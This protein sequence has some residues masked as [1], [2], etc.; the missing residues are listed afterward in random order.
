M[1]AKISVWRVKKKSKYMTLKVYVTRGFCSASCVERKTSHPH[2]T[3]ATWSCSQRSR[4]LLVSTKNRNLQH[5]KS[6]IRGLSVKSDWLR[7]QSSSQDKGYVGSGEYGMKTLRMLR[8]SG[9]ARSQPLKCKWC[10]QEPIGAPG[11]RSGL[12]RSLSFTWEHLFK[13][14][15]LLSEYWTDA[16]FSKR[17]TIRH[18]NRHRIIPE[19]VLLFFPSLLF[20]GF[21]VESVTLS[22]DMTTRLA[23]RRLHHFQI[24]KHRP[25]L[26]RRP[27]CVASAR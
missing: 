13:R 20:V 23:P 6:A 26:E 12:A 22:W 3:L 21:S 18:I 17:K 16:T 2:P 9:P 27:F 11:A 14:M 7:K 1:R 15:Q 4:P 5:R 8:K 10:A 25:S 24:W 19:F